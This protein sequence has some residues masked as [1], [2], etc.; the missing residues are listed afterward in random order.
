MNNLPINLS[1]SSVTITP[2]ADEIGGLRIRESG[3]G[4]MLSIICA[5]L[6]HKQ[7]VARDDQAAELFGELVEMGV[8]KNLNRRSPY[9][10]GVFEAISI[11][12]QGNPVEIN[13]VQ[14]LA[15][16]GYKP[17]PSDGQPDGYPVM[18][19]ARHTDD[20]WS[21][22]FTLKRQTGSEVTRMVNFWGLIYAPTPFLESDGCVEVGAFQELN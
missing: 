9:G 15:F 6:R 4:R 3:T 8:L 14:C 22:P 17:K 2:P 19:V 18:Y 7:V 21:V 5:S 20:D 10:K 11:P 13:G 1:N 12:P 16:E